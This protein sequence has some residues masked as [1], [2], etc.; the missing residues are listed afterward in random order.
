MAR[1]DEEY[2]WL[3]DPFDEKKAAKER[4]QAGMSSRSKLLIGAGC[5]VV[6]LVLIL[7]VFLGIGAFGSL[8]AL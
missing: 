4:E 1:N 8:M 2:N 3:D 7:L 5:L 6:V